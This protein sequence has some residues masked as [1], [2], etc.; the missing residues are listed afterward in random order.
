MSQLSPPFLFHY[1]IVIV[2][3]IFIMCVGVLK[4]KYLYWYNQPITFRFT[5]RRWFRDGGGATGR[6][7]NTG[8]MNPLSLA[9][10]CNNA[11]VYP[12][13]H[14][15]S[16]ENVRVYGSV[17]VGVGVGTLSPIS[18]APYERIAAFL[19]RRPTEITIPSFS[20][21][22]LHIPSDILELILSQETHGL[23][24]FIGVLIND[25]G[26]NTPVMKGDNTPVMK[27]DNTPVMKGD[28]TPVMKGVCVLTPRIMLSFSST[29]YV[30]IYLCLRLYRVG[31]VYHERTRISH[32][33]RNNRIYSE[34]AR[35]CR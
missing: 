9:E 31:K 14:F 7:R 21:K 27:G 4:F 15:V 2:C 22:K 19:S 10:R 18:D 16:H 29:N 34:V 26:D 33:S 17:G 1:I 32:T 30:C 24:A 13:L 35:D 11:V 23:S 20:G 28:N 8:I 6:N 25:E 3:L 12:F 5:I